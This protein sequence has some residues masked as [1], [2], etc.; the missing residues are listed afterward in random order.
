MPKS[1]IN[2]KKKIR[3]RKSLNPLRERLN[4]LT[5]QA[6]Q[7]VLELKEAGVSEQSRALFEARRTAIRFHSEE[8][9]QLFTSNLPSSRDI[10]REMARVEQFLNDITSSPAGIKK[11]M[12]ESA[13]HLFGGQYRLNGGY[14]ANPDYV[15][16]D[17]ANRVFEIYHKALE[18]QGGYERVMGWLKTN[19]SGLAD[20]GSENL[21]NAIY[22]MVVE[23]GDFASGSVKESVLIDDY[24]MKASM[25]I[26][27]MITESKQMAELQ[28]LGE[29]YGILSSSQKDQRLKTEIWRRKMNENERKFN[30]RMD[31]V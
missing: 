11:D 18:A 9:G 6:N 4:V 12:V 7:L 19:Y 30:D 22:D 21:I 24:A 17:T 13:Q 25:L 16:E 3:I 27:D 2:N 29:D 20:Y 26:E 10:G 15:D 5:T 31:G 8:E 14:G 28:Q 23:D 1:K